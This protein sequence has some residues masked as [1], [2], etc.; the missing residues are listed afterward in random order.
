MARRTTRITITG[1]DELERALKA[2]SEEA[3][4]VVKGAVLEGAGIF[5]AEV[6]TRAPRDEGTLAEEGFT[7]KEGYETD[8]SLNAIV[9]IT[10]RKFEYAF[11]NEF[12]VDPRQPARPFIRPAFD[13]AKKR[14]ID[15]IEGKLRRVFV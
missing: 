4:T 6:E 1:M 15:F 9:T 11:Y 2:K 12:G 10:D 5:R 3:R 8:R 7:E 13:A 14:V